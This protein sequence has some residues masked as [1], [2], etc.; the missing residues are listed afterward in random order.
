MELGR[1]DALSSE[2]EV[3][4]MRARRT[5]KPRARHQVRSKSAI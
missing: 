3:L 5:G 4:E 2:C 1:G